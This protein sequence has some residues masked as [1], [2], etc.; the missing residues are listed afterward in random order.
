MVDLGDIV[1]HIS[2]IPE[3]QIDLVTIT[4]K[5][6]IKTVPAFHAKIK[7]LLVKDQK[8]FPNWSSWDGNIGIFK[9]L[10]YEIFSV[11]R[12]FKG[13]T[14]DAMDLCSSDNPL[15]HWQ[16]EDMKEEQIKVYREEI[17]NSQNRF[18][19]INNP[20]EKKEILNTITYWALKLKDEELI[21]QTEAKKRSLDQEIENIKTKITYYINQAKDVVVNINTNLYNDPKL[22]QNKEF[23]SHLRHLFLNLYSAS[24]KIRL[25]GFNERAEELRELSSVFVERPEGFSK[26]VF[27]YLQRIHNIQEMP[28]E[29][30]HI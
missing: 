26:E 15:L 28:D 27:Q 23:R 9:T 25:L 18:K 20:L 11:L 2:P 8:L 5:G 1:V 17:E 4:E 13:L 10:D 16:M 19:S 22:L 14:K 12:G 3:I 7:E 29:L 21:F 24:S 30:T 6:D